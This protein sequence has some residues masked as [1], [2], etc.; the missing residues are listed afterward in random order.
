MSEIYFAGLK[1]L[2]KKLIQREKTLETT[3]KEIEKLHIDLVTEKGQFE[4]E[5]EVL[6]IKFLKSNIQ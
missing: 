3:Y 5:Y 1:N 4:T 2:E 6:K